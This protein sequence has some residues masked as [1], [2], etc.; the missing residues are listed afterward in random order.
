M[1]N[2]CRVISATVI[3]LLLAIP[4]AVSGQPPRVASVDEKTLREY[5]GVYQWGRDAFMYLQIWSEF[6]GKNELVAFDESGEART[7][8]PTDRDTFF[9]GPG[10]AASAPI[11]S[12]VV[13]Q[14]EATGRIRS[15][16]RQREGTK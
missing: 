1:R 12:R 5:A 15:L 10:A 2:S 11:E 16:K 9:A 8:Y 14:R 4:L 13:F 7:L 6:T 3:P